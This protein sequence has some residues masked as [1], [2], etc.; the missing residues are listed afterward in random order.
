MARA[1]QVAFAQLS[2]SDDGFYGAKLIT[3]RYFAEHVLPEANGYRDAIVNGAES[4]LAMHE[5][6][7]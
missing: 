1:A 3:A 6:L 4:V 7:F 2:A 5:A